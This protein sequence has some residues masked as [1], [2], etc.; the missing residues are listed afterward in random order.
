MGE[1]ALQGQLRMALAR[2]VFVT[3]PLVVL[4]GLLSGALSNGGGA[5]RWYAALQK[6][7]F[8]PSNAA[9]PIAWTALYVLLGVA[10][11]IVL[12]ARGSRFRGYALALFVV[13]FAVNLAWSPVFFV[14]HRTVLGFA[15]LVGMLA[16]AIATTIAFW[17]VRQSA[18]LLMLPYLAW[19]CFAGALNWEIIRL[20]PDAD[21]LVVDGAATQ[22]EIRR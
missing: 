7:W 20:N 5:N 8:Q 22:I 10:V 13:A 11:A 4:L 9:F 14:L 1:V 19:L 16:A 18:G 15:V 17:R 2:R 21:G 6:P 3:V 12:N